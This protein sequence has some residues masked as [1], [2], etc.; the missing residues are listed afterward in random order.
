MKKDGSDCGRFG[1]G[2]RLRGRRQILETTGYY[3]AVKDIA[4]GVLHK[5]N[6][7]RKFPVM[8]ISAKVCVPTPK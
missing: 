8:A 6:Y 3:H 7:S 4:K 2:G 5:L 1:G